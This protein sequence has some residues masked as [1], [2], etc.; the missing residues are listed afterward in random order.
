MIIVTS[1]V[2]FD[3]LH[4]EARTSSVKVLW[5]ALNYLS[6]S[7]LLT[8]ALQQCTGQAWPVGDDIMVPYRCTENAKLKERKGKHFHIWHFTN[9]I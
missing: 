3:E 4:L 1:L 8:L 9:T 2:S 7:C 5:S 6:R